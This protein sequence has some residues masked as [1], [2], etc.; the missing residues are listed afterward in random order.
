MNKKE[1]VHRKPDEITNHLKKKLK[2]KKDFFGISGVY[3]L[4]RDNKIIYI[5]ES[6]CVYSRIAQH[7]KEGI[8]EFN[9]FIIERVEGLE[10][11]KKI[12]RRHIKR[13]RPVCNLIHNPS[14]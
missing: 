6:S 11:R 1:Y 2:Q 13:F 5:G 8:K 14:N 10:K 9:N 7:Y 12:E 3:F 4:I